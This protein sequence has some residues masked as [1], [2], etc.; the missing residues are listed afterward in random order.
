MGLG[1]EGWID[2][3]GLGKV[4]AGGRVYLVEE[5]LVCLISGERLK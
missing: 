1:L 5:K 4:A 3:C 2:A